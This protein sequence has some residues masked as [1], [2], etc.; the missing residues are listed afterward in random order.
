MCFSKYD[1]SGASSG[2]GCL[3][4]KH[5]ENEGKAEERQS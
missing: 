2:C 3:H 1:G 5:R 4:E